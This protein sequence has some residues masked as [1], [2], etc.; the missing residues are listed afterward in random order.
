MLGAVGRVHD[1]LRR[2]AAGKL[3]AASAGYYR[4]LPAPPQGNALGAM[5]AAAAANEV[6]EVWPE[7]WPTWQLFMRVGT[8][9][10]VG[11]GGPTGLRYE[12]LYPLLDRAATDAAEWSALL[13]DV[14]AMEHAALKAM[15]EN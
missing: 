7:N 12:A 3:T 4:R 15:H 14:Q 9:W 2:G 5:L 6:L 13:D 10:A 1:G 11:M 8:Q